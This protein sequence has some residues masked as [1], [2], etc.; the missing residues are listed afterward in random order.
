[1]TTLCKHATHVYRKRRFIYS[2]RWCVS[3]LLARSNSGTA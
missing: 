3:F 1:M 2:L